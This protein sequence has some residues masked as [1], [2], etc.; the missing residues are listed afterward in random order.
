MPLLLVFRTS[1]LLISACA[2]RTFSLLVMTIAQYPFFVLLFH[3]MSQNVIFKEVFLLSVMCIW[4]CCVQ[5]CARTS[6]K[7]IG[8]GLV[9]KNEDWVWIAVGLI[10]LHFIYACMAF[11]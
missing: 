6:C 8:E 1:N 5:L 4:P 11:V 3:I 10:L 9:W 7:N 2:Q